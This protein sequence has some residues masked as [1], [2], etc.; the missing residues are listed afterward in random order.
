MLTGER[1]PAL[2]IWLRIVPLLMAVM[3]FAY[4]DRVNLGFAAVTMN[5]DLGLTNTQFGTAAGIFALGY[6][7]AGIPSTLMLHR[8]G[9]RRWISLTLLIWGVCSAATAFV[10]RPEE[11][12]GARLLLGMAEAS[13]APGT[14]VYISQWFPGTY[15]GRVLG[16][17]Y[18]I[19][20]LSQFLGGPLSSVLLAADGRLGLA[21]WQWLFIVEALPTLA[22]AA[23]VLQLLPETPAHVRWLSDQ[24]KRWL[25]ASLA[26]ERPG[27]EL[28]HGQDVWQTFRDRRVW[29]LAA[30]CAG[31][32]TSGIGA[33]IFLPLIVR[34]MGFSVWATGFVSSVPAAA[35]AAVMPLFGLWADRS[36]SRAR[37]VAA[38]CGIIACGLLGAAVLLPS[39]WAIAPISI[40]LAAFFGC[41]PAFWTLPAAFL[42]GAGAA[43]GI[44][45]I[46]IA[47]NLGQFAGP[48]ILGKLSD[49][50]RTY[51]HGLLCLAV[52]AAVSAALLVVGSSW[53]LSYVRHSWKAH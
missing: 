51:T 1:I 38:G 7:L 33:I 21:G 43:A 35:A 49:I 4:L 2:T 3:F 41:L 15:R 20:P 8:W 31:L 46:N 27:A 11:L 42:S 6:A 45:F 13:L 9:A 52:I 24:Q 12:F 28:Q 14:V 17:F 47:G 19:I 48:Y 53:N 50:S 5:H 16:T 18:M 39:P 40:A 10:R 25:T 32:G 30:F 22:L 29:L 34:S 36:H 37:V 44:A 26:A 23:L